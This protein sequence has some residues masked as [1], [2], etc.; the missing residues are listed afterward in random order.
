MALSPY[1]G[2]RILKDLITFC[3]LD[4]EDLRRSDAH[5]RDKIQAARLEWTKAGYDLSLIHI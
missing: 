4:D 3:I 2:T 1:S 5:I